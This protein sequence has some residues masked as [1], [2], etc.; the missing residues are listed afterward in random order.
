MNTSKDMAHVCIT[1]RPLLTASTPKLAPNTPTAADRTRESLT[2]GRRIQRALMC[3]RR[4]FRGL[5][6]PALEPVVIL[7][8]EAG[9]RRL[10]GRYCDAVAR[11]D[12]ELFGSLWTPDAVWATV[13]GDIVGRER[14]VSTYA[15]LRSR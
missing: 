8:A 11:F 9:V 4:Y 1:D 12:R 5:M 15:K 2:T 10:V 14:I 6:A 3:R 13:G 7:T